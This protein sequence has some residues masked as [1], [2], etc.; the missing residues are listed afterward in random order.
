MRVV[1]PTLSAGDG[2]IIDQSR[3]IPPTDK[4]DKMITC[5]QCGFVVDL[6]QRATG[7]SFGAI[8]SFT[9]VSKTVSPPAPGVSFTDQYADPQDTNS[10]CPFCNSMNPQ[11]I[12]RGETGFEKAGPDFSNY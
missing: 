8:S 4:L 10:G 3:F 6:S 1:H 7:P 5:A 2:K 9:P 12:G 11:A